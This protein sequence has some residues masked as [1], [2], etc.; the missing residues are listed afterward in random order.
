MANYKLNLQSPKMTTG[1]EG[2]ETY[3][4]QDKRKKR[5]LKESKRKQAAVRLASQRQSRRE[6]I[7]ETAFSF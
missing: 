4:E 2:F 1:A 7:K 5:F 3:E 6:N